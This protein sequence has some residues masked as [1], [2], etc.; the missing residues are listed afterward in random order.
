MM[1]YDN[2]KKEGYFLMPFYTFYTLTIQSESKPR[3][4]LSTVSIG[5]IEHIEYFEH[6]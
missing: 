4:R 5:Y 6:F 2:V 1:E 3:W